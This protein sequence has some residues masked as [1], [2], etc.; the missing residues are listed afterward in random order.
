MKKEIITADKNS[1]KY[2]VILY[3]RGISIE[4]KNMFLCSN[5]H[6]ILQEIITELCAAT[7]ASFSTNYIICIPRVP[8]TVRS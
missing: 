5:V 1:D 2:T 3:A 4:G 7:S 8:R 6:D